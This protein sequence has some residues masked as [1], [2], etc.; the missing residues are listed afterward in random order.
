MTITY[1]FQVDRII[2][3]YAD[4][5]ER[6]IDRTAENENGLTELKKIELFR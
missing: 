1:V 2:V 6:I 5:R 4:G 3:R